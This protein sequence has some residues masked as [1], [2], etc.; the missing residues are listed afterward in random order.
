MTPDLLYARANDER[1]SD[2]DDDLV[3]ETSQGFVDGHDPGAHG[4]EEVQECRK[5]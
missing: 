4:G 2:N 5:S 1:G 3:A